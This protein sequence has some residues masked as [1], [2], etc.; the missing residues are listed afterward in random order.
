M[1]CLRGMMYECTESWFLSQESGFIIFSQFLTLTTNI[2]CLEIFIIIVILDLL[3]RLTVAAI[4]QSAL[5][6]FTLH[7]LLRS[8]SLS[9]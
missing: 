8:A 1:S 2:L 3:V 5:V 9:L 6:L 4:S 7:F